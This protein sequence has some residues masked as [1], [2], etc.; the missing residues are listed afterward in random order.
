MGT[1]SATVIPTSAE[2]GFFSFPPCTDQFWVPHS[3]LSNGA[4]GTEGNANHSCSS[5]VEF[6][7]VLGTLPVLR[8]VKVKQSHYRPGQ[9]LKVPGG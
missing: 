1:D 5:K 7:K 6:K 2:A 4:S 8:A 3:I 9:A